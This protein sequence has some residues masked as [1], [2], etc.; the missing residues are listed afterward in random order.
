MQKSDSRLSW[1]IK[2]RQTITL[3][4]NLV[5]AEAF[6][7]VSHMIEIDSMSEPW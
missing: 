1:D 7:S 2:I 3:E 4:T 6:S 5:A